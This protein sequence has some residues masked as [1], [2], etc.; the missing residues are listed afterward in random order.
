MDINDLP[1]GWTTTRTS[2]QKYAHAAAAFA[3]AGAVPDV[4]WSHVALDPTSS[5][6]AAAPVTLADGERLSVEL[7]LVRHRLVAAAGADAI[8]F[9]LGAG[10]PPRH[11]GEAIHALAEKHGTTIDVER[12]R[13]DEASIQPYV[14]DHA[15][16]F[17]R[18]SQAAIVAMEDLNADLIGEIAGPHL[19][20]HGFDIATEWFS[21]KS[22][23]YGG[24]LTNA[25]I[26]VGWYPHASSYVY[27]NPWQGAK[28]DIPDGGAIAGGSLTDLG[29]AVHDLAR[30]SMQA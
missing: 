15:T 10:P 12:E 5:G 2:L 30:G 8:E 27:V 13:F 3:R 6:F 28:L 1:P 18:A 22:V 25:Q 29:R 19:W 26:A 20:P 9:D 21:D 7:D 11:V 23:A 16:A 17:L 4:R 24:S 14:A